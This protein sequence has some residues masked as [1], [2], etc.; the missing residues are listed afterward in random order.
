MTDISYLPTTLDVPVER[1][2]D[3][4]E[5]RALKTAIVIGWDADDEFYFATSTSSVATVNLLLDLAKA[6]CLD[7]ISD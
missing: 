4:D 2:L 1:V 7:S 3:N 6:C 5:V